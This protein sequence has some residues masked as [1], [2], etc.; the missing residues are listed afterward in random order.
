MTDCLFG[1]WFGLQLFTEIP[2]SNIWKLGST[3]AARAD[4]ADY[5]TFW[6]GPLGTFNPFPKT[7]GTFRNLQEPLGHSLNLQE[8]F[9]PSLNLHEPLGPFLKF[10]NLQEL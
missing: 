10:R 5:T 4:L 3:R 9:I 1:F 6:K 8:P 2:I 7:S